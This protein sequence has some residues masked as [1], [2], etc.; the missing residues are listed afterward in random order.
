MR[1]YRITAD[2]NTCIACCFPC[3]SA[4]QMLHH[5]AVAAT[6]GT[7]QFLAI[8]LPKENATLAASK[9][10]QQLMQSGA[11]VDGVG[12]PKGSSVAVAATGSEGKAGAAATAFNPMHGVKVL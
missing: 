9:P 2:G 11:S 3:C 8:D 6:P 1:D 4:A 10:S 5:A 12:A 7:T